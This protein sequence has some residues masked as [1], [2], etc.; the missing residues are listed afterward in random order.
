MKLTASIIAI[1]VGNKLVIIEKLSLTP[2]IKVSYMSTFF[3]KACKIMTI[4][5]IGI[6]MFDI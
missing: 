4:I 6:I 1:Y 5:K 2:S 3:I